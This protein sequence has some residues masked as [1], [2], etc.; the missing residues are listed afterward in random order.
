MKRLGWLIV[1]VALVAL[2]S[3]S[4]QAAR[5]DRERASQTIPGEILIKFDSDS[6]PAQ[7]AATVRALGG[8]IFDRVPQLGYVAARFPQ[9]IGAAQSEQTAALLSALAADPLIE[10]AEPN[11]RVHAYDLHDPQPTTP[12]R[13][14][15]AGSWLAY[16]PMVGG[17]P[18]TSPNDTYLDIQYAWEMIEAFDG[19]AISQGSPN[20]VVAVIDTGV[21]L[22]HP[23]L[24]AKLVAGYDFVENDTT[25]DDEQGH[26]TH[27]A[28]TVA[29]VTNN[30]IGVAGTCP[31]CKLM[32]VRV[33]DAAGYGSDLDVANGIVYAAD[34]GAQVI[35]MS[36]GGDA[37]ATVLENAVDYAWNKGVL[38]ACAA[39]NSGYN[40]DDNPL[41]YPSYYGNCLA[42]GATDSWDER[43]YYSTY[44]QWV[45][46]AAPGDYIFS[47]MLG[48]DYELLSGTSMATPHVA[49]VAG[50]LASQGLSQAQIRDR[51][52]RTADPIAG[53]GEYWSNG[54]LNLLR[55]VRG[56]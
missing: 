34:H 27:V 24:Q 37:P 19:W 10:L 32:P 40:D 38:V 25:P 9:L 46:I 35:N 33:L 22:D 28:G 14:A 17:L 15:Q 50:L 1:L 47:T 23:D 54:R 21:Q 4:S 31:L 53:T 18:F 29:A 51:L 39:G 36:L 52:Q 43:A 16:L 56:Y 3:S 42:V 20:V 13:T 45:D 2:P 6:T 41:Q 26:G 30:G 12:D 8:E 11:G 44:G 49:G 5:D 7:Q 55:A 48:S